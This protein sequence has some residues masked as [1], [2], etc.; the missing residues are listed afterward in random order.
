MSKKKT[1]GIKYNSEEEVYEDLKRLLQIWK[2]KYNP[3][4]FST[5]SYLSTIK[6]D[7]RSARICQT[8]FSN[9]STFNFNEE[10]KYMPMELMTE[11]FLI[12]IVYDNPK[13][14]CS[15]DEDGPRLVS[16]PEEKQTL[17]VLVAFEMG[18]RVYE[19]RSAMSWGKWGE[20]IPYTDKTFEFR[21][22]IAD[23]ADKVEDRIGTNNLRYSQDF[24]DRDER[25]KYINSLISLIQNECST[26]V[27]DKEEKYESKYSC[28]KYNCKNKLL[29]LVNKL[30][31]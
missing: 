24:T 3:T 28:F 6:R 31:N 20:K 4:R 5:R 15:R 22:T 23:V 7:F 17:P 2:N 14:L 12:Q 1:S 25:D 10:I 9:P 8:V 21:K 19:K 16:I 11:E 18:K 30:I 27:S 29:I 26:V 13:L